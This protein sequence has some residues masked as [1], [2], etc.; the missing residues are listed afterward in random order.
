MKTLLNFLLLP[1]TF[2]LFTFFTFTFILLTFTFS[3]FTCFAQNLVPN[4]SFE[5][6]SGCPS[7]YSQ[8][9]SVLFWETFLNPQFNSPDFFHSCA[10]SSSGASVPHNIAGNSCGSTGNGCCGIHTYLCMGN[11]YR[12]IIST[13][14]KN[15]L[16]IGHKYYISFNLK[17]ANND[18]F[19]CA[20]NTIGLLF[21]T[22][23]DTSKSLI[24]NFATIKT[25]NFITD[26]NYWAK[27]QGV[28]IADSAYKYLFIGNFYDDSYTDTLLLSTT[29]TQCFSY[30]Y[31][32]D[33]CVSE[34]SLTCTD[35]TNEIIDF[36]A[37]TTLLNQGYCINYAINT[38]VN[39]DGYE[40]YFEGG[41][42][43][44]SNLSNPIVCY[45]DTGQ[46]NVTLIA[47][48]N[49][50]CGDTLFKPSYI[51]VEKNLSITNL[52]YSAL[53]KI[54][55][56]PFFDKIV[57]KTNNNTL[58]I[59]SIKLTDIFEN[60]YQVTIIK[61]NNYI[62]I[63]SKNKLPSGIYLLNIITDKYKYTNKLIHFTN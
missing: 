7:G 14:L 8:F 27:I 48:N 2:K 52:N 51:D 29:M 46:F 16:I 50:G 32:D 53:F 30:Y 9:D 60:N 1:F 25:L 12:E 41:N 36:S 61:N 55:P 37:D 62:E 20:V 10:N 19:K 38:M 24:N 39:Y 56:N 5:E 31:I 59:K 3:L 4:P 13:R 18:F 22:Y 34:D 54:S 40:W 17:L 47:Y 44:T 23:N 35:I 57:I 21:T 11:N 58:N 33:I 6:Y 43:A 26:T 28:F 15:D 49:N 63:K 42:P 45:N